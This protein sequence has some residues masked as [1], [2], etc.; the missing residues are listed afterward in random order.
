MSFH[1]RELCKQMLK[2]TPIVT[3]LAR[4]AFAAF[5][6]R[7]FCR[8]HCQLLIPGFWSTCYIIHTM[9][10]FTKLFIVGGQCK[11]HSNFSRDDDKE[12]R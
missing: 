4:A 5:D 8:S 2:I 6:D 1:A 11:S 9:C 3:F 7:L 10:A 12:G